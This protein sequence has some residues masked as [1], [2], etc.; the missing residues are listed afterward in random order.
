MLISQFKIYLNYFFSINLPRGNIYT[1]NVKHKWFDVLKKPIIVKHNTH[2]TTAFEW[3]Q[4]IIPRLRFRDM[5][6]DRKPIKK[7]DF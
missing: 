7:S 5:R 4:R 1:S 2:L 6:F 3:E